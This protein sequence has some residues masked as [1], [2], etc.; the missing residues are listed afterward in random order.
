MPARCTKEESRRILRFENRHPR[1]WRHPAPNF[2]FGRKQLRAEFCS[3]A[4]ARAPAF[5]LPVW[6]GTGTRL[7]PNGSSSS[8]TQ[9]RNDSRSRT[10]NRSPSTQPRSACSL[11]YLGLALECADMSAL[12]KAVTCHCTSNTSPGATTQT[13]SLESRIGAIAAEGVLSGGTTSGMASVEAGRISGC[14]TRVA[15]SIAVKSKAPAR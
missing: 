1:I 15:M 11:S 4:T 9:M 5:A 8:L 10:R 2:S 6:N 3:I 13:F 12:L 14:S 7:V